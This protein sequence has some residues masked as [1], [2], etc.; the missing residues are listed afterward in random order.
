MFLFLNLKNVDTQEGK[1]L[2][3]NLDLVSKLE[4]VIGKIE[5]SFDERF[6]TSNHSYV[7]EIKNLKVNIPENT[8]TD[9]KTI[10]SERFSKVKGKFLEINVYDIKKSP[11]Q[12]AAIDP[13]INN[14]FF[15]YTFRKISEDDFL[16]K[17]IKIFKKEAKKALF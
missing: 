17:L 12:K 1:L 15:D 14:D 13:D 7:H 11:Y 8:N 4:K 2:V 10:I 16:L 3:E 5:I 9:I 6:V